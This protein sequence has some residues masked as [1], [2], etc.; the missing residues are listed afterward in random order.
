MKA[1]NWEFTNRALVFG[2]IFGFTFPLYFVD[3]ENST[4]V[5]AN[6]LGARFQMDAG[7][8]AHFLFAGAALLLVVAALIRTW[9]SAYLQAEIVYAADVKS[10]SLVA[11]G[12]YRYVRNPLY[13]ANVLM[14]VG[15]GSMMSRTGFLVVVVAMLVFCYRL[16]N[17]EE[18]ELQASQGEQYERYCRAVP[19]LLPS[20]WPRV[21]A[22]GRKANWGAGFKAESWYWGFAVALMAFA[23]TLKIALF[24]AILAASIGLLWV[25]SLVLQKKVAREKSASQAGE[26]GAPSGSSTISKP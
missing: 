26:G 12:P 6:W 16:I 10:Q 2:L 5:L 17:R 25:S 3:H 23:I 1:T 8:L 20:L 7:R 24:F 13:A 22:S 15:M 14:A 19:R 4:A 21:A 9:A 11:D 18:A